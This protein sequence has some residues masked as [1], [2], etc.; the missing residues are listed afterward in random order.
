MVTISFVSN[1]VLSGIVKIGENDFITS[2][3]QKR[4]EASFFQFLS[5]LKVSSSCDQHLKLGSIYDF[6]KSA[7][8]LEEREEEVKHRLVF[9]TFLKDF[10]SNLLVFN[11]LDSS[12]CSERSLS[13]FT[14]NPL[15]IL[16]CS[17]KIPS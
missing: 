15:F 16:F 9:N 8:E 17:I 2:K 13:Y 14:Q 6:D 10:L 3:Y 1:L 12:L 7:E 5:N 11:F 4:S